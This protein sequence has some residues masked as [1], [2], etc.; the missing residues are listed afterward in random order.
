MSVYWK[1][2]EKGRKRT[3]FPLY[4]LSQYTIVFSVLSVIAEEIFS[5]TL[6]KSIICTYIYPQIYTLYI[7][8][9]VA[10]NNT[11]YISV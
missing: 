5:L 2:K 7:D 6:P 10:S 9:M 3:Q 4:L 1:K 8:K 11:K